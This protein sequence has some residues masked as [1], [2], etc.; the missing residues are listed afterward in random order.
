MRVAELVA[1]K[2]QNGSSPSDDVM[3]EHV[4]LWGKSQTAGDLRRLVRSAMAL[5]FCPVPV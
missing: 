4:I 3:E 2:I 1:H 5:R